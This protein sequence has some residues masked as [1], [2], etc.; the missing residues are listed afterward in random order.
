MLPRITAAL[1]ALGLGSLSCPG[2]TN[3]P[4]RTTLVATSQGLFIVAPSWA[5]AHNTDPTALQAAP[6]ADF[7]FLG[8]GQGGDV[9]SSPSVAWVDHTDVVMVSTG[10]NLDGPG[11]L[12]RVQLDATLQVTSIV[13][14][15]T[16][17][18]TDIEYSPGLDTLYLLD[19]QNG[20]V[21]ALFDPVHASGAALT[22]FN[23]Q[24]VPGEPK[25]MA[26]DTIGWPFA[27]TVL[28]GSGFWR[29]REAGAVPLLEHESSGVWDKVERHPV[30]NDYAVL[31][32]GGN[33]FGL[34]VL[35]LLTNSVSGTLE[36]NA[37]GPP[38]S[39]E[40]FLGP[41]DFVHDDR[42]SD[43][44]VRGFV[45]VSNAAGCCFAQATGKNHVAR[46]PLAW[47]LPPSPDEL[48]LYTPTPVSGITGSKADLDHVRVDAR[49]LTHQGWPQW[50][51]DGTWRPVIAPSVGQGLTATL[52]N[53]PPGVLAVLSL[54]A[55]LPGHPVPVNQLEPGTA[56][57][58]FSSVTDAA[59]SVPTVLPLP[60]DPALNGVRAVLRWYV[61]DPS[62][63]GAYQPTQRVV[64]HH[65]T[66]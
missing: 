20:R 29:V 24:L 32:Q 58:F 34:A 60:D 30:E 44:N 59:G 8:P 38:P 9:M 56:T 41:L 21:H 37:C 48:A 46:F 66:P 35:D 64:Y 63:G 33:T 28:S 55:L 23:D 13:D 11:H 5:G 19:K 4:D 27:L 52:T 36:A 50:T 1:V 3:L 43:G 40:P 7:G 42:G 47:S 12:F 2:Q 14:L 49:G 25:D 10:A 53:A 15:A 22:L 45:A 17:A 18:F 6:P 39:C 57:W 51:S 62:A 61:G 65:G 16:G 26:L 31:S 54:H